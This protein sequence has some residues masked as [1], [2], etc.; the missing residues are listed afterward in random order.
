[1]GDPIGAAAHVKQ[2]LAKDRTWMIVELFATDQSKDN[3][4]PAGRVYY[5]FSTLLWTPCSRSQESGLCLGAQAGETR[6]RDVTSAAGLR[7][8][9]RA[10]E[11]S[12]NVV[13]E[14]RS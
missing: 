3:L 11:T 1:M 5:S 2:S 4:N 7:R 9:H 14:A 13:Y 6:I 12:F 8:F 10:T